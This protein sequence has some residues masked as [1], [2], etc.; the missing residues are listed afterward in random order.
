MIDINTDLLIL[1]SLLKGH[2]GKMYYTDAPDAISPK[3]N[4]PTAKKLIPTTRTTS[5][6]KHQ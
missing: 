4:I 5:T 2:D 3:A 1:Y 6:S